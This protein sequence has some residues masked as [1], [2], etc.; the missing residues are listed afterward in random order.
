MKRICVYCGASP[1]FGTS[2]AQAASAFGRELA[3]KG[4]G[5]IYGGGN[6]GVMGE[7]A[8]AAFRAGGEVIGVIPRDL[9]SAE[10]ANFQIT[11]LLVV[12]TMHDRKALMIDMADGF[13][14]LPGGFGTLEEFFEVLTWAQ[15]GVHKKPCGVFNVDG[16]FDQLLGFLDQ[17]VKAQ[18]IHKSHRA[19]IIV[20]DDLSA[21]LARF[22]TYKPKR[23]NKVDWVRKLSEK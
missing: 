23:L 18:F 20:E 4:I 2:F 17:A 14:A 12:P 21:M 22:E 13:I 19:M 10:I 7:I 3:S 11:D 8:N 6:V 9:M 15:L 16:Y 1:G 5:L